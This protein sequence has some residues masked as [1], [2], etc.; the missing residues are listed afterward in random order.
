MVTANIPVTPESQALCCAPIST[1][2]LSGPDADELAALLKAL[3][4]PIRLRL[5][6]VIM[7]APNAEMCTCDLP[8]VVGRSQPTVSHHLGLLVKAGLLEREQRGKWAW[9]RPKV[10][11]LSSLAVA[12]TP[13]DCC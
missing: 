11:R 8:A 3:A 7:T 6:S 13:D 5:L 12:L 9:F 10:D 1:R 4:D 2:A